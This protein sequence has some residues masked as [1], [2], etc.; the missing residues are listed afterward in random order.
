MSA[1]TGVIVVVHGAYGRPLVEAAEE[2]VGPLEIEVVELS[3]AASREESQRRVV[4][5]VQRNEAGVGV[6]LLTDLRGSTPA[7]ICQYSAKACEHGRVVT[8]LCLPMLMKLAT[9]DRTA[10]AQALAEAL[11]ATGKRSITVSPE[12]NRKGGSRGL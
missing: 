6:L 5:A 1:R 8:G 7:N 9:S 11:Q 2:L 4:N 3:T 10:G 12:N